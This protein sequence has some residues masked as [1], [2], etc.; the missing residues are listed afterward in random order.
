MR[1]IIESN[2]FC[3]PQI[4]LFRIVTGAVFFRIGNNEPMIKM[5]DEKAFSISRN[6]EVDIRDSDELVRPVNGT[7]IHCCGNLE[8]VDYFDFTL[9]TI[10]SYIFPTI[11][12]RVTFDNI[13]VGDIF[14]SETHR[15][16]QRTDEAS[17]AIYVKINDTDVFMYSSNMRGIV[18]IQSLKFPNFRILMDARLKIIK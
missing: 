11:S 6:R 13:D 18:P 14:I 4:E 8:T 12:N 16:F 3:L 7:T 2:G 5:S 10:V 9:N 1:Y 17:D 15:F